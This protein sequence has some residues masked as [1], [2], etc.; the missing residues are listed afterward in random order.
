MKPQLDPTVD[1]YFGAIGAPDHGLKDVVLPAFKPPQIASAG[2]LQRLLGCELVFG[3]PV[4]CQDDA[5]IDV[6]L[7]LKEVTYD[8]SH[9]HG[10]ME[11]TLHCVLVNEPA[12]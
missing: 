11:T 6:A 4:H 7:P 5:R 2:V 3:K 8:M 1:F 12:E 10:E 9:L